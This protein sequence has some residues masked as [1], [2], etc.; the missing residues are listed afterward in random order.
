MGSSPSGGTNLSKTMTIK[1]H[2]RGMFLGLVVGDVLG[3]PVQ[4][5]VSSAAIREHLDS[6]RE[7]H[8]NCELPKGVYT[9]D[10]SMALC[11]ADSLIEK[12]GYNSYD[13]MQ[14]YCDWED[15]GY[16][17]YFDYGFDV[18]TQVIQSS[19]EYS[20]NKIVPK[21]KERTISAGNG[22]I[23]RLA[24]AIIAAAE[25]STLEQTVELAWISGRETHYSEV[26]EMG[27]EVFA[28]L[29]YRALHAG[30]AKKSKIIDLENLYF[31]S[32]ELK[33]TW[34]DNN[35]LISGRI[36]SDGECLRDLGGYVMDALT[37]AIWAFL[38]TDNFEDGMLKVLCLGGDTDTNC[39]IYGQLA[40]AFY[41]VEAIPQN[42]QNGL[43]ISKEA[44]FDLADQLLALD[45]CP[46]LATRFEE[47]FEYYKPSS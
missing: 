14:K 30:S 36:H 38:A 4:F 17:S 2:S 26:A 39:A 3:A 43:A 1:S 40:G 32:D 7:Y 44:I 34:L 45:S 13:I 28:D 9:D 47:D 22:C 23:M 41:G 19:I 27:V 35:W 18:G 11:L 20:K 42:W 10:T 46:I 24:P 33:E 8:D 37:I 16:R 25:H 6:L 5:G 21:T 31:T 15:H 29:L 12:K